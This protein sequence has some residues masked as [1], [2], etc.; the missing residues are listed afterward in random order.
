MK[1][2][3]QE[4][5][6]GVFVLIGICLLTYMTIS[7]GNVR[8]FGSDSYTVI[9]RFSTVS[10][11][12]EGNP[13]E[14]QGIEV[15]E[16][17]QLELDQEKQLSVAILSIK[18]NIILYDDA[19]AS[20]KTAGLIG[21]K[22]VSLNPGGSGEKLS[23]GGVIINTESPIDI[24]DIIGK[25]AFGSVPGNDTAGEEKTTDTTFEEFK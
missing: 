16:V 7:L 5:I 9:T 4:S 19:I 15:G 12:R 3:S 8:L 18:N 14:M 13:V 21:D 10:G 6:A 1:K 17:K 2:V 24:G 20:I 22:F 25:Y 11:L 23:D